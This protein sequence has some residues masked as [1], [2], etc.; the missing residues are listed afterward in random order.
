[1]GGHD[2][3]AGQEFDN[4]C[5]REAVKAAL[6]DVAAVPVL[7]ALPTI[8]LWPMEPS[9]LRG[10]ASEDNRDRREEP[11]PV[12]RWPARVHRPAIRTA[13]SLDP[14]RFGQAIEIA[15]HESMAPKPPSTTAWTAPRPWPR[16]ELS[17]AHDL[18]HTGRHG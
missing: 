15:G 16:E 11:P 3:E 7:L 4:R 18:G 10:E 13:P 8:A 17:L 2:D 14:D 1:M 12:A 5:G 6:Y 9:E